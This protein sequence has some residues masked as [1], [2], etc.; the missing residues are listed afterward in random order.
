MADTN[1]IIKNIQV[2]GIR[3]FD[4]AIS[5]I[6]DIIKLTVGE[7]D[8]PTPARVKKPAIQAIRDDFS[9]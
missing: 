7:P 6:P 5:D 8:L 4:E 1:H 3:R 2:S 9:H